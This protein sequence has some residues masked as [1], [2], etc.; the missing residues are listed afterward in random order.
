MLVFEDRSLSKALAKVRH[1]LGPQAL[2][3]GVESMPAENGTLVRIRAAA[4]RS[5]RTEVNNQAPVSD[6]HQTDLRR[7]AADDGGDAPP[8]DDRVRSTVAL[9]GPPGAGKSTA[10]IKL[11]LHLVRDRQLHAQVMH[12][13]G[14]DPRLDQLARTGGIELL[15]PGMVS[16]H[17]P[18]ATIRIIDTPGIL[19]QDTESLQQ[20]AGDLKRY[21]PRQIH[22]VLPIST[23]PDWTRT[24]AWA[25]QPIGVNRLLLTQ[26]DVAYPAQ[27]VQ[28]VRA[29]GLR[30]G[31]ISNSPSL[32]DDLLGR[33]AGEIRN[34]LTDGESH[35]T[36]HV[37]AAA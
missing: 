36:Q 14:A 15:E 9:V 27:I 6:R 24:A 30:L 25:F 13:T 37:Q 18:G 19:P 5:S 34:H 31:F 20:L 10:A 17:R 21:R 26:A 7:T 16:T 3:L 12:L 4:G 22:L 23:A 11:A 8:A 28:L 1:A 29:A 35:A 32:D 33:T 2:I